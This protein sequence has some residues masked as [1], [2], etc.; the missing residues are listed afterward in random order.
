M[1]RLVNNQNQKE[2]RKDLRR[3]QT[4]E[5]EILWFYLRNQKM[6]FKF[7]RQAS[8]G[9]FIADFYCREKLLAVE[10]DGGQHLQNKEYD[11]ERETFFKKNNIKTL[12]FWNNE[13]N[14]NINSVLQKIENELLNPSHS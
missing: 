3:N 4:K 2:T 6:N 10:L 1:K 12:R 13:I 14:N 5:E 7:K 9:P 11:K 8:I